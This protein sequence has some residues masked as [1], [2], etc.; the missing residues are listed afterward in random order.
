MKTPLLRL[1][2][3]TRL[4]DKIL[5][6]FPHHR[7]YV[8]P[9]FGS[10]A[11]YFAKKK[12]SFS[13]LNDID[14]EVYNLFQVVRT[15]KNELITAC[16]NTPVN[17]H[18]FK[19]W[20]KQP[21][22]DPVW[23]AVRFL[24]ISN[25]GLYGRGSTMRTGTGRQWENTINNLLNMTADFGG[26]RFLNCD[27]RQVFNKI[28]LNAHLKP[29]D[30]FVYNDPP[31]IGTG[32]NYAANGGQTSGFRKEDTAELMDIQMSTG[33]KFAISE[34]EGPEILEL[35]RERALNVY[36]LASRHAIKKVRTEILITNYKPFNS[37]FI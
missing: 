9:F 5:P 17:E 26:A 18:L 10:G 6:Y 37:L 35:A 34:F 15:R 24:Y 14:N 11:V 31:Y 3:K 12:V 8:E 32:N 7:V 29:S 33:Y 20:A 13:F 21:E 2:N 4:T 19:N 23:Q 30:V 28:R 25:L 22:G 16:E 27:F 1:G 36:R